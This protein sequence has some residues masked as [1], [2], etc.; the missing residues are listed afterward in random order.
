VCA[1]SHTQQA[2][3]DDTIEWPP[4]VTGNAGG[5]ISACC[6]FMACCGQTWL[7]VCV[8][9]AVT[10]PT[11]ILAIHTWKLVF[12][13]K[14]EFIYLERLQLLH[15]FVCF[16]DGLYWLLVVVTELVYCVQ[17]WPAC[18]SRPQAEPFAA[19][20]LPDAYVGISTGTPRECSTGNIGTCNVWEAWTRCAACLLR[21][22]YLFTCSILFDREWDIC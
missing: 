6:L 2:A 14:L 5:K 21:W 12:W 13:G 16:R 1:V 7:E 8:F 3:T 20:H 11:K 22:M 18:G 10:K 19:L 17:W 9:A 15:F 4:G